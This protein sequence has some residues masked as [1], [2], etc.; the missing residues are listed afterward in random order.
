MLR[1]PIPWALLASVIMGTL[2]F[3]GAYI[4]DALSSNSYLFFEDVTEYLLNF[5]V[6]FNAGALLG[7]FLILPFVLTVLNILFAVFSRRND[8]VRKAGTK[9][10]IGTL[11]VGAVYSAL[12]TIISGILWADWDEQIS[13][14]DRH[15]PVASWTLPTVLTLTALGVAG[16]LVLRCGNKRRLP[17]PA[18]VAAI[19]GIYI[20]TAV[21]ALWT[22]QVIRH[23][24]MLTLLPIDFV[25][26]CVKL[27]CEAVADGKERS[28]A[29]ADDGEEGE[30]LT[31]SA[32]LWWVALIAA[33]V[34]LCG[35]VAILTQLGQQ[36]DSIIQAWT[37]TVGWT[38]SQMKQ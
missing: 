6:Y 36:P 9:I 27:I 37:Q 24:F 32:N 14:Y 23:E 29:P 17:P 13:A 11:A 28:A 34:L 12:Y 21:C 20:G 26:I 19:A 15:L 8:L 1:H 5:A 31:N 22:V 7:V 2:F 35:T 3:I 30:L 10:E 4:S 25:L 38:F 16:Y 18:A 33:V